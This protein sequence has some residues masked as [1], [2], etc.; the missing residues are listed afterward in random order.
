M[1]ALRAAWNV[2]FA[3]EASAN[4]NRSYGQAL[5][6]LV[7]AFEKIPHHLLVAAAVKHGYSL[8]LLR[9]S[10]AAYR[11]LRTLVDNKVCS[12]LILAVCGI[13]AGS[14]TATTE[15]RMLVLDVIDQSYV[16]FPT[17]SLFVFVDDFTIE[18]AG[19]YFS[20]AWHL[21]KAIDFIVDFFQT[22]LKLEVSVDKS[23]VI[24]CTPRLAKAVC[25][26]SKTRKVKPA[27]SGKLLGVPS[28]GGRRRVVKHL[29]KRLSSFR[30][31][32]G[33]IHDLR[34][35][36]VR[37]NNVVRAAGTPAIT[38]GVEVTG[39]ADTHLDSARRLIAR[40]A[41]PE[42]GGKDPNLV[43]YLLD[44]S[45]GSMDP[46]FDAHVL[47]IVRYA[48]AWWESWQPTRL[49]T[50]AFGAAYSRLN[51]K[52]MSWGVV[53]GPIA[54]LI[55]SLARMKW[56]F[57]D[58]MSVTDDLGRV[59]KLTCDPPCVLA[60]AMKESVRRWRI[61]KILVKYPTCAPSVPD[62]ADPR[63]EDQWVINDGLLPHG[64]VDLIGP[65]GRLAK[66]SRRGAKSF[67]P[68]E[69]KHAPSLISAFTGGQWCQ[70]RVAS[71]K[72]WTDDARC[73]LCL[74]EN[75][76][77]HHRRFCSATMPTGGWPTPVGPAQAG[78]AMLST[79]RSNI[80]LNRGLIFPRI[81]IRPA[82]VEH[83]FQWLIPPPEDTPF[84]AR[85]YIDG[86]CTNPTWTQA[87]GL[88][89]AMILVDSDGSL[90]AAGKGNPPNWVIDS[91]GAEVWA[92]LQVLE[93]FPDCSRIT[94]DYYNIL[95]MLQ[96][97]RKSATAATRPLARLW[98]SIY[99]CIDKRGTIDILLKRVWRMPSHCPLASVGTR[100]M[101]NGE[102]VGALDWRANR[103]VDHLARIAAELVTVPD[104][105]CIIRD[106]FSK[107]VEYCAASL[108]V[109]THAANNHI[110]PVT[111]E[112]GVVVNRKVRDNNADQARERARGSKRP[113][114][115]KL[116][117]ARNKIDS[118]GAHKNA[119]DANSATPE[120]I[121]L[122][123][124]KHPAVV[125]KA[126]AC[127]K[128]KAHEA[129]TEDSF[130]KSWR[131]RLEARITT[132]PVVTA[133]ERLE[134]VRVRI[135]SRFAA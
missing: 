122:P 4:S 57:I 73:Q 16:L 39:M 82:Q 96:S 127:A 130:R 88:G 14:G 74:S 89:F 43:L 42:G 119:Y 109:V 117:P 56:S 94:T 131:S 100:V 132:V 5:L 126:K 9:L 90:L 103:L 97:G 47:P 33:R 66:G 84:K 1:G 67:E 135:R 12:R 134:A 111:R 29:V 44:G 26:A 101:S 48:Y 102:F 53:N 92:F 46:A 17:I 60:S 70:G 115:T 58:S 13:T 87:R 41:A 76:T 81:M 23:I 45:A 50:K 113:V 64:I 114:G 93:M 31:K 120:P 91:G 121:R 116:P 2:S 54:A 28:A 55:M 51:A 69:P 38:Y 63:L 30:Q 123:V 72:A 20:V 106:Q 25:S 27:S 52:N 61:A 118:G 21:A 105:A 19:N 37:T 7:K 6:D 59:Y 98:R 34:R 124:F 40:A 15:L 18:F 80:A 32:V 125:A 133:A 86:S 10:L 65:I 99:D 95:V 22:R 75:G 49:L 8:I 11:C 128:A 79:C 110:I 35:L 68:W 77:L 108:G 85:W 36:G 3:A 129:D 83:S 107:A 62:Y 78:M 24:G 104:L 112:D 71:T